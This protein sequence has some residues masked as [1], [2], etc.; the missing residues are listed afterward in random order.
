MKLSMSWQAAQNALVDRM[1]PTS[2]LH[3]YHLAPTHDK[4]D[5]TMKLLSTLTT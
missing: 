1:R 4:T 5:K 2:V 3:C